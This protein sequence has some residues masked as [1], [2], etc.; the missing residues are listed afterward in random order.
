MATV[1]GARKSGAP[2][3]SMDWLKQYCRIVSM[4]KHLRPKKRS[5]GLPAASLAFRASQR[6]STC[7]SQ[8]VSNVFI[9][10]QVWVWKATHII[11]HEILEVR[12]VL[13]REHGKDNIPPLSCLR[14]FQEAERRAVLPK[15]MVERLLLVPAVLLIVDVVVSLRLIEMKL[16]QLSAPP[17]MYVSMGVIVPRL[18]LHEPH[19]LDIVNLPVSTQPAMKGLTVDIMQLS[20]V[21]RP[22][23]LLIDLNPSLVERRHGRHVRP[24]EG[25]HGP[26][27]RTHERLVDAIDH[28]VGE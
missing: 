18:V 7:C 4:V 26:R 24:R 19:A 17:P 15:A 5:E 9:T 20:Q 6:R 3:A 16:Q 12:D 11:L 1:M 2:S 23:L 10:W 27:V 25:G 28:V 14:V 22:R 8:T 13:P 21:D